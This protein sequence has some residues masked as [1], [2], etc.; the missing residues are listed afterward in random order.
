[1][2]QRLIV[3]FGVVLVLASC[4]FTETMVLNED[5]SGRMSINVDMGEFMGMPG[6]MDGDSAM[7]KQDT[8]ILYKTLLTEKKDSIASLP[9]EIQDRLNALENYQL[10]L[11]SDPDQ[12]QFTM[13][14]FT[15]FKT[16]GEA[17]DILSAFGQS[18]SFI[19]G[20]TNTSDQE[21]S[22]FDEPEFI[23]VNYTFERGK[24]KRDAFI[25][26]IE[27]HQAQIDSL[28]QTESFMDGITYKIKYTFPRKI[29][30]TSVSDVLYSEDR[31]T[32]ELERGFLEYFKNP[33]VLDLEVELE[34]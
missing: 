31:K 28:K 27:G 3:V 21:N 20:T 19:P 24:F 4:Q 32:M 26:N 17:N 29:K 6:V 18:G 16:V 7:T 14:V 5:G 12:K 10:H 2:F 22:D 34:N 23:G 9:K 1:M 13:D 15:D 30:S 11:F 8:I 33:D 25:K